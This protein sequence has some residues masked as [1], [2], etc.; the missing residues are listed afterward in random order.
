[1]ILWAK[2]EIDLGVPIKDIGILAYGVLA[3]IEGLANPL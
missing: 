2:A 3:I 1:L